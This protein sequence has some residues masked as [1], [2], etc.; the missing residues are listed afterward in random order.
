MEAYIPSLDAVCD[1]EEELCKFW[2][3]ECQVANS[4]IRKC[5]V[6][7]IYFVVIVNFF[8]ERRRVICNTAEGHRLSSCAWWGR[9]KQ[10][11]ACWAAVVFC[12][13]FDYVAWNWSDGRDRPATEYCKC[14]R[15]TQD[16]IVANALQGGLEQELYAIVAYGHNKLVLVFQNRRSED[17]RGWMVGQDANCIFSFWSEQVIQGMS[18]CM[19]A[20]VVVMEVEH[21]SGI[22]SDLA[23][24]KIPSLSVMTGI[25]G[26]NTFNS[27]CFQSAGVQILSLIRE[28]SKSGNCWPSIHSGLNS[29]LEIRVTTQR[30]LGRKSNGLL[31]P[32]IRS[33]S[34]VRNTK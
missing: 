31:W 15:I 8:G 7:G 5:A 12:D 29:L 22:S 25:T 2:R 28:M 11:D 13:W 32:S 27:T 23:T 33:M 26:A 1:H 21:A 20:D 34:R 14:C 30:L 9:L 17:V 24:T 18:V 4:S 3:L 6:A 19:L 10:R 16:S